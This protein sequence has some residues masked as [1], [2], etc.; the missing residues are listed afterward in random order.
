[1]LLHTLLLCGSQECEDRP[2]RWGCDECEGNFCD[3]CFHAL[4]RKGRRASHEPK[5]MSAELNGERQQEAPASKFGLVGSLLRGG[6]NGKSK[7]VCFAGMH[8]RNRWVGLPLI[9]EIQCELEL[10]GSYSHAQFCGAGQVHP[11]SS[12]S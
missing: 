11:A 12:E 7:E 9:E 8:D 2:P 1:M 10:T 6:S 4:H 3:V 5:S